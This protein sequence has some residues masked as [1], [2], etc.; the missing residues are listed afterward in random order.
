MGTC[1]R[2]AALFAAA[3]VLPAGATAQ[4]QPLYVLD[5]KVTAPR[6]PD[7]SRPLR[8]RLFSDAPRELASRVAGVVSVAADHVVVDAGPGTVIGR[9]APEPPHATFVI[10]YDAAPVKKLS[11]DLNLRYGKKPSNADLAEFVRRTLTPSGVRGFDIAS[12]VATH[13]TCDCS[14]HAVLL[15]A[16]A[17]AQGLPARVVI[18]TLVASVEGELGGFG[19]AWTEIYRDRAWKLV[20]ATPLDGGTKVAYVPEGLLEDESAGFVLGIMTLMTSGI[21]R[22]EVVGNA[23]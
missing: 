20:D 12:Q 15:A 6:M 10:D 22:V 7:L 4:R 3:L 14:E 8:L 21:V 17:R 13:K 2:A 18:G 23:P 9:G 11:S 5:L 16:L 1:R 19:H